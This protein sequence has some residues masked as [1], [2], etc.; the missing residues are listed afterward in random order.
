MDQVRG[1]TDNEGEDKSES[2]EPQD[3]PE[4]ATQPEDG[5]PAHGELI[6]P[7]LLI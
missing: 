4:P 3:G 2:E 5:C 1:L 7:D 6:I